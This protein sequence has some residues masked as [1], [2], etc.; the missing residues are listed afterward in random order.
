MEKLTVTMR[1]EA[2]RRQAFGAQELVA[3]SYYTEMNKDI[4]DHGTH[5]DATENNEIKAGEDFPTSR[6]KC[7][8]GGKQ[9]LVI[10]HFVGDKDL[11]ELLIG[12]A[13]RRAGREMGL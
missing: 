4:F 6:R 5:M 11:G 9:F 2:K 3:K 1:T 7:E 12:L 13:E 8:V 10:R